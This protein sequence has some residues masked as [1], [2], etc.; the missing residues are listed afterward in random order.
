M[1]ENLNS[2]WLNIKKKLLQTESVGLK[3]NRV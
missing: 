3:L 2:Q 1:K